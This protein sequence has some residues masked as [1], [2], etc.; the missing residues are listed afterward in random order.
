[1]VL[2]DQ[3]GKKSWPI[4]GASFILIHKK[5]QDEAL[6]KNMLTYFDWC[7][8][9]GSDIAQKLHYVPIPLTV[10]DLVQTQW[11]NDVTAQGNVVWNK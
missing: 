11:K 5:Q 3:P 8:F 1:M 7:Y 2:T 9:H 4:T 10:V 6:T